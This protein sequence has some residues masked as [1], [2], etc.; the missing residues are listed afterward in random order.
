MRWGP[1]IVG[2]VM[3]LLHVTFLVSRSL[4]WPREFLENFVGPCCII[5]YYYYYYYCMIGIS[6]ILKSAGVACRSWSK[7]QRVDSSTT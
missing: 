1:V 5:L 2:Y 3:E 7:P 4:M 6:E